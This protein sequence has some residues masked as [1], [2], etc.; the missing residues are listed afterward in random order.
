MRWPPCGQNACGNLTRAII[1]S[2]ISLPVH[3]RTSHEILVNPAVFVRS[4]QG[5]AGRT[6]SAKNPHPIFI[7]SSNTSHRPPPTQTLPAIGPVALLIKHGVQRSN[8]YILWLLRR[9]GPPR[10][11]TLPTVRPRHY[12]RR[13]VWGSAQRPTQ[14]RWACA[15]TLDICRSRCCLVRRD[16]YRLHDPVGPELPLLCLGC[17]SLVSA[18]E[19][20]VYRRADDSLIASCG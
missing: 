8:R 16:M 2:L 1:D 19:T 13:S 3:E 7:G 15:F 6:T 11:P 18:S 14:A 10:H 20:F 9:M 5:Q 4:H 12:R 17:D